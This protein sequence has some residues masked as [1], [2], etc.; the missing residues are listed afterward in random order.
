MEVHAA[1]DQARVDQVVLHQPQGGEEDE[2]RQQLGP[3]RQ[4]GNRQ[5]H[6]E[7]TDHRNELEHASAQ[8]DHQRVRHAEEGKDGGAR[9]A[10]EDRG[11]ELRP[12]VARERGVD[13]L[14]EFLAPPLQM[15]FGQ[16]ADRRVPEHA[17]ALEQDERDDRRQEQPR[18][19]GQ[20]LGDLGDGLPRLDVNQGSDAPGGERGHARH[21]HR[22]PG[23]FRPSLQASYAG[24]TALGPF[25]NGLGDQLV[26]GH[27]PG[28][29]ENGHRREDDAE[30]EIDEKNRGGARG[31]A[32][33]PIEERVAPDPPCQRRNE[34]RQEHRQ[35]EDQDDPA[36][37]GAFHCSEPR[38]QRERRP[39]RF[40]LERRRRRE[41]RRSPPRP[42]SKRRPCALGGR[43]AEVDSAGP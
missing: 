18:C 31:W 13:V 11:R 17:R 33:A 38:A 39:G 5:H 43:K 28:R 21:A 1:A 2:Q 34:V 12:Q 10:D 26:L 15:P 20:A 22:Q 4:A 30:P 42:Q 7:R 27:A 25:G 41:R 16:G 29:D 9:D 35:Q 40:P 24:E 6:A 37:H 14:E 3:A 8:A 19:E 23:A 32:S 36:N